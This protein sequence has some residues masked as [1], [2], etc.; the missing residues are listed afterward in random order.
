[1]RLLKSENISLEQ[2]GHIYSEIVGLE[3]ESDTRKDLNGKVFLAI[4]GAHFNGNDFVEEALRQ[5]ARYVI[6]DEPTLNGLQKVW[7]VDDVL[8]AMW[9]LA[10]IHRKA[11]G[12]TIIAVAGS[13]G[14]TSTKELLHAVLSAKYSVF[15]T[16]GNLNN[17]IGVPLTLW[18]LRPEHEVAVIEIGANHEG[19]TAELAALVE[20]DWGLVTNNGM[21]HLEGFGSIEG[22]RRANAEL[23]TYLRLRGRK[24]FVNADDKDLMEDSS[25]LERVTYGHLN[26]ADFNYESIPNR[27]ASIR[28]KQSGMEIQ[29]LLAGGFNAV[30]MAASVVV[31]IRFGVPIA[32]VSDAISSYVPGLLRSQEILFSDIRV[33]LD[34]YNANPSSMKFSIQSFLEETEGPRCVVLGDMLEMG[35]Y[36]HEVH[37]FILNY[38]LESDIKEIW[39]VG[40][41]FMEAA[42]GN[43]DSR[44]S[45][46]SSVSEIPNKTLPTRWAGN[47]VLLKGSRGLKLEQLVLIPQYQ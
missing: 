37:L 28:C 46:F 13:N 25:G 8:K 38:V 19:E 47:D 44:L 20:P 41:H 9:G 43:T 18:R 4:R 24:A 16:P 6:A 45:V 32:V 40:K 2:L 27:F 36:A 26:E 34:A 10:S 5:G 42:S 30:N 39:L 1:V 12:K 35:V 23:Y 15:S 22:V 11:W 21:D 31:G 29:S 33:R 7:I 14:K 3:W 17:H